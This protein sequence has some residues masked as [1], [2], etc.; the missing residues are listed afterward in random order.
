MVYLYTYTMENYSAIKKSE[1]LPFVTTWMDLHGI[2]LSEISYG[3]TNIIWFPFFVESKKI[4][5]KPQTQ[6]QRI[7]WWLSEGREW[8][9]GEI[10]KGD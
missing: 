2:M 10:D 8:G 5:Q 7:N 1:I 9:I 6:I 3:K 4:K